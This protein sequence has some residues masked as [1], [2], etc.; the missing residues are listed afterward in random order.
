[1]KKQIKVAIVGCGH[2][3]EV[4]GGY[5][6]EHPKQ[7]KVVAVV[8]PNKVRLKK[9]GD[10]YNVKEEN[11]FDIFEDFISKKLELDAV[12][13]T[14]MDKTHHETSIPI[15]KAGYNMLLEKP[16][17]LNK[18]QVIDIY[19]VSKE[20]NCKVMICHVLRYT[21]FYIKIKELIL[22]GE[23][24][25]VFQIITE[26]NVSYHH[27]ATA[28][29]RGKWNNSEK[30]GSEMLMSKC[31]HDLDAISWLKSGVKPIYVSSFG[32][33]FFYKE[34][35]AP[36]GSGTRCLVDCDIESTC[37]YSARKM[38]IDNNYWDYYAREYLDKFEDR[39]SIERLEW[40]FKEK[41]PLGRCV[42]RSDNNIV[43]HQTA[44]IE[45]EDGTIATHILSG[46]TSKPS[47]TIHIIGTKGELYGDSTDSV[48][49]L[50]KPNIEKKDSAE[51]LFDEIKFD[52][53]ST[54]GHGGGDA[55]ISAD[56]INFING[57]ETSISS[58][59][60]GDSIYGHVI[61]FDAD[62]AMKE[63]RVVKINLD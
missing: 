8:D 27:I 59:E 28:F 19:N 9:L 11:R 43:D 40:S 24:G 56:F 21:P 61:G 10:L 36:K 54:G 39:D 45:Y 15:L 25:D 34:E 48:I 51:N 22:S 46:A 12:I 13:N 26:E 35:N 44:T 4:Y 38:H 2:R 7:M 18:E 55:R 32:G 62:I 3:G 20:N 49:Y 31:C 16:I 60:I 14:T 53:D 6:L 33:L 52:I 50:R 41:N 63:R 17:A 30:C 29:I 23:L 42:F 1:M 47:R 37:Q 58:T 57:D 5:S